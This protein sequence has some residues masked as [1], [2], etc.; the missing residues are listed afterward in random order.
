MRLN[1]YAISILLFMPLNEDADIW[2]LLYEM[3]S[4]FQV[5]VCGHYRLLAV[6]H[7]T[8]NH[9]PCSQADLDKM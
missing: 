5:Q 9:Q 6:Y 3:Q 2:I 4:M 8:Y 1:I 7:C